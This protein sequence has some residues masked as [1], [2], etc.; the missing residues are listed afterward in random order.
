MATRAIYATVCELC[1]DSLPLTQME[2]SM[3]WEIFASGG[4]KQ[5]KENSHL[6]LTESTTGCNQVT[7]CHSN[8][9]PVLSSTHQTEMKWPTLCRRHFQFIFFNEEVSI[10]IKISLT[11]ATESPFDYKPAL[12]QTMIWQ[13]KG[14]KPLFGPINPVFTKVEVWRVNT[15]RPVVPFTNMG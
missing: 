5:N 14:N 6:R 9:A 15:L 7:H 3:T 12:V 8:G 2:T 10:A 1:N 4:R 13:Q 11:F